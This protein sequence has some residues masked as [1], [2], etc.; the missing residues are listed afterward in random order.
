MKLV[1]F[2][3][4][5]SWTTGKALAISNGTYYDDEAFD[6]Q[7]IEAERIRADLDRLNEIIKEIPLVGGNS[8]D[9]ML[10]EEEFAKLKDYLRKNGQVVHE[11]ETEIVVED[12]G[13]SE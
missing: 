1:F 13:E 4:T 7:V 11:N 6:H 3:D 10:D 12:N 9:Y 8:E 5:G 2:C